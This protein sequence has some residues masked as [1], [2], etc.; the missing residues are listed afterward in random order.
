[1]VKKIMAESLIDILIE[2]AQEKEKYFKNYLFYAKEIKKVAEKLLGK[3]R[4]FV[5]GSI[6]RKKEVAR[7]IDILIISP[8]LKTTTQKSKILAKLW[9]KF[10]FNNPFEFHLINP[11]EYK[12]WYRYFIK[13]KIEIK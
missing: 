1:M 12:N 5:F 8:K 11:D 10:G 13:K 2:E 7:D 3:V 4:V 9:K 6:L